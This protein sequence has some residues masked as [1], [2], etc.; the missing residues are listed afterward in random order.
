MN[1]KQ[2]N[3]LVN[4]LLNEAYGILNYSDF[5]DVKAVSNLL[6]T[7]NYL[8]KSFDLKERESITIKIRYLQNNAM[9]YIEE[10][11]RALENIFI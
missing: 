10:T 2:A 6:G 11:Q 5:V 9:E 8:A 1:K 4:Y 7:A 3:E